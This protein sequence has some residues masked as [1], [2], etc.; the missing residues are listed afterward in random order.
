MFVVPRIP[1]ISNFHIHERALSLED[2]KSLLIF[3]QSLFASLFFTKVGNEVEVLTHHPS[4]P[5]RLVVGPVQEINEGL[6]LKEATGAINIHQGAL[7]P[8]NKVL[9]VNHEGKL[10]SVLVC[11]IYHLGEPENCNAP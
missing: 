3:V 8:G 11:E 9:E 10:I 6:I 2:S 5:L 4:G 1:S 7:H